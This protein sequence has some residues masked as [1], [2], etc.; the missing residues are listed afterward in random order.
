MSEPV[1]DRELVMSGLGLV[2]DVA[3]NTQRIVELL[4][5][6]DGEETEED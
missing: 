3:A 5:E 4:E 1:W 6:N 2:A